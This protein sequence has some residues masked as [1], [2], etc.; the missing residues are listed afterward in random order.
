MKTQFDING[1]TAELAVSGDYYKLTY[2]GETIWQD[3]AC[4][5]C[6][7][8]DGA[9]AFFTSIL[10]EASNKT[11]A[12]IK[13]AIELGYT[14]I[15]LEANDLEYLA[16]NCEDFLFA[17]IEQDRFEQCDLHTNGYSQNYHYKGH[18]CSGEI[19]DFADRDTKQYYKDADFTQ[20]PVSE[21]WIDDD[22]RENYAFIFD[23]VID[24]EANVVALYDYLTN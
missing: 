22:E 6:Y 12:V 4:S 3:S 10:D 18:T 24:D 8:E 19:F 14:V 15:N 7:S 9:K 17:A 13:R 20:I 21:V 16:G 23:R 1:F 2:K 5:D 11:V